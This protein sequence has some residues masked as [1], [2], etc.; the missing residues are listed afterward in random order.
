MY[1]DS[2]GILFTWVRDC[3]NYS[4]HNMCPSGAH[5][6]VEIVHLVAPGLS[7]A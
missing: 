4:P 5:N 7:F 6:A 2:S 3:Q 1:L